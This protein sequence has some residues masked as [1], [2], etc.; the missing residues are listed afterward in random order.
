MKQR[1]DFLTSPSGFPFTADTLHFMQQAYTEAVHAIA[2]LAG[3]TN[4]IISGCAQAGTVVGPGWLYVGGEL[5]PFA[6]GDLAGTSIIRIAE[7]AIADTNENGQE[8]DRFYTK[9]ATLDAGGNLDFNALQRAGSLLQLQAQA[10]T[11]ISFEP[12]V[13]AAGCL[14]SGVTPGSVAISPGTIVIRGV[15]QDVPAYTGAYPVYLSRAGYSTTD[16]GGDRVAFDPYTSQRKADVL[17]RAVT[18]IGE[19]RDVA[20]DQ[21]ARFDTQT[22]LGKWE[23]KGYAIA[24]GRN[25]TLDLRGRVRVGKDPENAEYE[26]VGQTG[27][28]ER[29][30][31]KEP[32]MPRHRHG[33]PV[34]STLPAGEF[35]LVK[36]SVSGQNKTVANT[37]PGASG[38]EPDVTEAP[39]PIPDSGGDQAHENR[40]PFAVT[41]TVQR[42]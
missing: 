5:I 6:G 35:G 17:N 31:L 34:G 39:I 33:S 27:G 20:I 23:W 30:Q 7:T 32:E 10:S 40:P 26:R 15:F 24:D 8:V 16:P 21:V 14:V 28:Q 1:I 42:I 18:R 4:V 11:L 3:S 36:K 41:F 2:A 25:G 19:I 22:G 38:I 13:I 37:D 12:A 9:T 29:V